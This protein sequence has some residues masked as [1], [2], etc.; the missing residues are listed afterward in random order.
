VRVQGWQENVKEM[1]RHIPSEYPKGVNNYFR[2]I[3]SRLSFYE[4]LKDS[5]ASLE[6][7]I[8]KSKITEQHGQDSD[9]L[10]TNM[11]KKKAYRFNLK[12]AVPY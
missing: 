5:A 4:N 7:A 1:L 2:F 12:D 11:K 10:I 6:L 3:E 9:L 8:W